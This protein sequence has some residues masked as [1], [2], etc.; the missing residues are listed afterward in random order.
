MW[1]NLT[2]RYIDAHLF[3]DCYMYISDILILHTVT[4]CTFLHKTA[5]LFHF[6]NTLYFFFQCLFRFSCF[7]FYLCF[8]T[9][10]T[11]FFIFLWIL[12]IIIIFVMHQNTEAKSS[13]VKNCLTINLTL[14]LF[15]W[16]TDHILEADNTFC[17]KLSSG[18]KSTVFP[19]KFGG[20]EE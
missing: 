8:L 3:F 1:L 14:I 15:H 19:L 12:L 2:L 10:S 5:Q 16:T 6:N 20:A 13:N 18:V 4:F 17:T 7:I 9:R 11:Y